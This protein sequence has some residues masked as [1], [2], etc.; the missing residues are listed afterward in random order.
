MKHNYHNTQQALE[1]S[2]PLSFYRTLWNHCYSKRNYLRGPKLGG[3]K[4]FFWINQCLRPSPTKARGGK[5]HR[6]VS[7]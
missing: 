2:S 1:L 7:I 3:E 4:A 5:A 6:L